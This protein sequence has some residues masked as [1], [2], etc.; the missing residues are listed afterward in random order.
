[1]TWL[2]TLRSS[3][4]RLLPRSKLNLRPESKKIWINS[5]LS[6]TTSTPKA[7]TSM[8]ISS[9]DLPM[10]SKRRRERPSK[11]PMSFTT[12]IQTWRKPRLRSTKS[13]RMRRRLSLSTSKSSTRPKIT[14]NRI[15][16]L[17]LKSR[18]KPRKNWTSRWP[19]SKRPSLW[20][21]RLWWKRPLSPKTIQF[22]LSSLI[23]RCS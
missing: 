2:S 15:T 3:V 1:M 21:L 12:S 10:V 22:K 7:S 16:I 8:T 11:K 6:P 5:R 4:N 20:W 23:S 9:W 19:F 13:L 17:S 14:C 18:I